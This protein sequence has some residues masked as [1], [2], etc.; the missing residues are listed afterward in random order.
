MASQGGR[1]KWDYVGQTGEK[2]KK[3]YQSNKI[4]KAEYSEAHYIL[5]N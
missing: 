5:S 3:P 2:K 4:S 1:H